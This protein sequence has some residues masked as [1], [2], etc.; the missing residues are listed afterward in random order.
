MNRIALVIALAVA[1]VGLS[2]CAATAGDPAAS[3][4]PL[5]PGV[6]GKAQAPLR[7]ETVLGAGTATVT[8]HFDRDATDVTVGV[9]G[10]DGL[11]VSGAATPIS[12]ASFAAG[13][14]TSFEVAFT[15][16]PGQGH[17]AVSAGGLFAGSRRATVSSF[18]GPPPHAEGNPV[19][20][21]PSQPR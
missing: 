9:H 16:G 18:A 7:I 5:A 3:K 11:A 19:K 21:M 20:V 13:Q 1:P 17:L 6:Q 12:G 4:S 8:V 2:A 15:A 14:S 10:V